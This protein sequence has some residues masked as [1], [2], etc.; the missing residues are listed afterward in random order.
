[1]AFNAGSGG[2]DNIN[3]TGLGTT[4]FITTTKGR[5]FGGSLNTVF[6]NTYAYFDPGTYTQ[7]VL[8]GSMGY[9]GRV[10]GYD[11]GTLTGASSNTIFTE[12]FSGE[13]YRIV[14]DDDLLT[15]SY[16]SGTKLATGV[17]AEYVQQPLELQIK[18]G[19]LVPDTVQKQLNTINKFNTP[20][21]IIFNME[22]VQN[23]EKLDS[24]PDNSR[25]SIQSE[26]NFTEFPKSK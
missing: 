6:T 20:T 4:T 25:L 14:I 10:Q 13:D 2:A 17:Y 15:G 18:P 21:Q 24:Q 22:T 19:Y 16:A 1:L 11:G 5:E 23:M 12:Q 26:N 7:N 8:S 9:Y 3:Q